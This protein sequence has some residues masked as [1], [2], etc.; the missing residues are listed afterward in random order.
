MTTDNLYLINLLGVYRRNLIVF[1]TQLASLGGPNNAP[2]ALINGILDACREIRDCKGKLRA[3]GCDVDESADDDFDTRLLAPETEARQ[4]SDRVTS[5]GTQ[6]FVNT[7]NTSSGVLRVIAE[8]VP[9]SQGAIGQLLG[10]FSIAEGELKLLRS[11]KEIHERLHQLQFNCYDLLERELEAFPDDERA[12]ENIGRY[13]AK[14]GGI[15]ADLRAEAA[16]ELLPQWELDF[17]D[18]L[19]R[20]EKQI[21]RA[22]NDGDAGLLGRATTSIWRV[23]NRA[24]AMIDSKMSSTFTNIGFGKMIQVLAHIR[25][26]CTGAGVADAVL[27]DI[28]R[29]SAKLV[30]ESQRLTELVTR[31]GIWQKID[32]RLCTL[33][34][35]D[36]FED[37]DLSDLEEHDS[38]WHTLRD[39]ALELYSDSAE[40]WALN[41]KTSAEKLERAVI[42]Q[43]IVKIRD[44]LKG[45]RRGLSL[46]FYL[47]DGQLLRLCHRLDDR[48]GP[49]AFIAGVQA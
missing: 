35:A 33:D 8:Q 43:D 41:I 32:R 30:E 9:A 22:L 10:M 18:S 24:P 47:A 39:E 13:A 1:R 16:K 4:R 48:N 29:I 45:Y 44:H 21:G 2:I 3:L 42:D 17:I 36:L 46:G 14:L 11:C 5:L 23:L 25:E 20:A 34:E 27:A 37:A 7:L 28:E 38:W 15:V 6:M 40:R 19:D 12:V 31:H 49:L 26:L